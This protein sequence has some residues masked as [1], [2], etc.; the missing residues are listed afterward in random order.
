MIIAKHAYQ[1]TTHTLLDV[2]VVWWCTCIVRTYIQYAK[3]VCHTAWIWWAILQL[4]IQWVQDVSSR[5]SL[6]TATCPVAVDKEPWLETSCTHWIRSCSIVHQI[7][8]VSTNRVL[9]RNRFLGGK[10][11]L[12]IGV[13]GNLLQESVS[14][15]LSKHIYS[16]VFTGRQEFALCHYFVLQLG[17]VW[18]EAWVF[19]GDASP[20]RPPVDWT[21]TNTAMSLYRVM[22]AIHNI[23]Y[24][25]ILYTIVYSALIRCTV[26]TAVYVCVFSTRLPPF[27]RWHTTWV[28]S[29]VREQSW[30]N[31]VAMNEEELVVC[32]CHMQALCRV[33]ARNELWRGW[34]GPSVL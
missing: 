29:L 32:E 1:H 15:P 28:S 11:T 6:S 3:H 20:P 30:A 19:G 5:G 31:H 9:S 8:V 16:S 23:Q 24:I 26:C 34:K 25:H 14:V 7:H 33:L 22:Y 21:L 13:K 17:K 10:Y 18:G 4:L 27:Y 12:G 2:C